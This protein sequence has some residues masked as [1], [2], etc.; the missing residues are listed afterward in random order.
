ME[1]S[2]AFDDIRPADP[3]PGRVDQEVLSVRMTDGR[4]LE[5]SLMRM[6]GMAF[7]Q[8]RNPVAS[9]Q[10]NVEGPISPEDVAGYSVLRTR[11]E[12]AA[13][14]FERSRGEPVPG[15]FVRTRDGYEARL[16]RLARAAAMETSTRR[17]QIEHQFD[18]VA[19]EILLA[20]TKRKWLLDCAR[21]YRYSNE[22]PTKID[23]SGGCMTTAMKYQRP[24]PQD[25]D[26]DPKIRRARVQVPDYVAND[27]L[28]T[29]NMMRTFRALG[30][31]A[32]A[33]VM[34]DV[35]WESA[36]LLV[37]FPEG[38]EKGRYSVTGRREPS[39]TMVWNYL[40]DGNGTK[41]D[42]RR[43]FRSQQSDR[44]EEFRNIL[45]YGTLMPQFSEKGRPAYRVDLLVDDPRPVFDWLEEH[46][47]AAVARKLARETSIGWHFVVVF[48]EE[49]AAVAFREC[50]SEDLATRAKV[51][52]RRKA[53]QNAP[54][55]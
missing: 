30:Y 39:G 52:E 32:R 27:P 54:V 9:L 20:Q 11:E 42:D 6:G 35:T 15:Y 18:D 31:N 48:G 33:S 40:W 3:F 1:L 28:S 50:W 49:P 19:D 4:H 46:A 37:D 36:D 14:R 44:F 53:L 24:R 17:R 34:G 5:G 43:R 47:G 25:F 38:R 26:P 13:E 45:V 12:V 22:E 16:D 21:W 51:S 2:D 55:P 7:L 23:L 8:V 10:P 41:T 29:W